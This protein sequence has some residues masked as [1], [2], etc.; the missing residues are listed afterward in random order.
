MPMRMKLIRRKKKLEYDILKKVAVE[1]VA[2][3][4]KKQKYDL[5]IPKFVRPK[6]WLPECSINAGEPATCELIPC[7]HY[8]SLKAAILF[9]KR[10]KQGRVRHP[11][12]GVGNLWIEGNS[13]VCPICRTP[14]TQIRCIS[15]EKSKKRIITMLSEA[16]KH[17]PNG[18]LRNWFQQILHFFTTPGVIDNELKK[19]IVECL[20][21]QFRQ[22]E[23]R[24]GETKSSG[25]ET[26]SSSRAVGMTVVVSNDPRVMIKLIKCIRDEIKVWIRR[27]FGNK[28]K[29][30]KEISAFD[31]DWKTEPIGWILLRSEKDSNAAIAVARSL[32]QST[33]TLTI[34][35]R[36][37]MRRISRSLGNVRGRARQVP[38]SVAMVVAASAMLAGISQLYHSPSFQREVASCGE[39]SSE[40]LPGPEVQHGR[41]MGFKV[42]KDGF[43]QRYCCDPHAS[44]LGKG[45]CGITDY[46]NGLGTQDKIF[47]GPVHSIKDKDKMEPGGHYNCDIHPLAGNCV[48][49]EMAGSVLCHALGGDDCEQTSGG[50]SWQIAD[51]A[52]WEPTE[53]IPGPSLPSE[54][55]VCQQRLGNMETLQLGGAMVTIG[56]L[57]YGIWKGIC[58]SVWPS[59]PEEVPLI[60]DDQL[61]ISSDGRLHRETSGNASQKSQGDSGKK[62]RRKR[63]GR[64]KKRKISRKQRG[65]DPRCPICNTIFVGSEAATELTE[66]C[67]MYHKKYLNACFNPSKNKIKLEEAKKAWE[68]DGNNIDWKDTF[69]GE[70]YG[71]GFKKTRR[72]K[73]KIKRRKRTRRQRG[74][75]LKKT[76]RRRKIK[77]RKNKN[78]VHFEY[79]SGD[80]LGVSPANAFI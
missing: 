55:A 79:I 74:G 16:T 14:W 47:E 64:R 49:Q 62:T 75:R 41:W 57:V 8:I 67:N 42:C 51:G 29:A 13:D 73:R 31:D 61:V 4:M 7:G 21:K 23:P 59:P 35:L 5:K 22:K 15:E 18:P 17:I 80:M 2:R 68:K 69:E 54:Q 20:M 77:S 44:F 60:G 39:L 56:V 78:T 11:H 26:K 38:G 19:R 36:D 66:H 58:G 40:R 46:N 50:S 76:R 9:A 45:A 12:R 27:E 52:T 30:L 28:S 3:A 37:I 1:G 43:D 53:M 71:G 10:V 6:V 32:P 72:K 24:G 33:R 34:S 65:G 63:G 48:G 25:G 70:D